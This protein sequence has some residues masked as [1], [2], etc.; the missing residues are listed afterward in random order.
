M[1]L[2]AFF[3]ILL[4]VI[5]VIFF[6][7]QNSDNFPSPKPSSGPVNNPDRLPSGMYKKK[8]PLKLYMIPM[9]A[10]LEI[11]IKTASANQ[12]TCS[13]SVYVLHIE[14]KCDSVI[15]DLKRDSE[16]TLLCTIEDVGCYRQTFSQYI[17]NMKL[18]YNHEKNTFIATNI[19]TNYKH[20]TIQ[21]YVE[22]TSTST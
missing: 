12:L 5:S 1:I 2:L 10:T 11:Q 8:V 9:T 15:V 17:K 18:V 3:L 21:E 16:Y 7:N 22:L 14:K 13:I 4:V 20:V 19:Q 6:I